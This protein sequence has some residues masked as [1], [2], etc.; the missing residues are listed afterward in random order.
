[1]LL[2]IEPCEVQSQGTIPRKDTCDDEDVSPP[3]E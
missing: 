3:L 1:M 2:V